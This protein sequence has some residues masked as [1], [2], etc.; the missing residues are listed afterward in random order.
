MEI[1]TVVIVTI[2]AGLLISAFR[3][4]REYERGVVFLLGRF[5]KVKGPGL[6]I[7]IPVVQQ[8]VRVLLKLAAS[9]S[10]DAAD[11]L[12]V[13]VCHANTGYGPGKP[14]AEKATEKATEK[15][16]EKVTAGRTTG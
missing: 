10:H 12:A 2:V 4:L 7:V 1:F 3:V 9:P 11:A 16:K 13:A 6:I 5:Y 15:A 14:A 8:M